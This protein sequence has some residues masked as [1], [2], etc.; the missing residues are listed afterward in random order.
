MIIKGLKMHFPQLKIIGE[1]SEEYKGSIHYAYE[2]IKSDMLP[3]HSNINR[4]LRIE[5]SC[6]WIDPID[7]TKGF[8]NG[9]YEDVTVLIGLS[10]K[11]KPEAGIIGTPY[12]KIGDK[13]VFEPVVT[14]GSV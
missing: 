10:Y 11:K 12:K 8:L 9:N 6:L 13:K 5:D 14:I 4:E 7:C 1:E 3:A 2:Q